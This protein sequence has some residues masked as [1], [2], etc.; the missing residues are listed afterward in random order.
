MLKAFSERL[1]PRLEEGARKAGFDYKAAEVELRAINEEQD[2]EKRRQR[3]EEFRQKYE[4]Q[5]KKA[6]QASGID[7]AEERRQLIIF[8]GLNPAKV[9]PSDTL[10]LEIEGDADQSSTAPIEA[11]PEEE[12]RRA[13]EF[14]AYFVKASLPQDQRVTIAPPLTRPVTWGDGYSLYNP[15]MGL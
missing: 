1:R 14:G 10:T 2:A 6:L 3:S 15:F 11:P 13:N 7:V 12:A 8:L 4:P 9:K 5:Y